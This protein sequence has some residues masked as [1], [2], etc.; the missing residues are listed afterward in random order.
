[1]DREKAAAAHELAALIGERARVNHIVDNTFPTRAKSLIDD[2]VRVVS[3]GGSMPR[4]MKRS[5]G[6]WMDAHG[7]NS[8]AGRDF[9]V[10]AV[11]VGAVVCFASAAAFA[12]IGWWALLPAIPIG[13]TV[14]F[15]GKLLSNKWT[16][17]TVLGVLKDNNVDLPRDATLQD[18]RLAEYMLVT[19]V[20]E[21]Q[22]LLGK[23]TG[24]RYFADLNATD[25]ANA[26]KEAAL[27][28]FTT[29]ESLDVGRTITGR[30]TTRAG[31]RGS[32]SNTQ[33]SLKVAILIRRNVLMIAFL[34]SYLSK[35]RLEIDKEVNTYLVAIDDKISKAVNEA[36]KV[37][38]H[39]IRCPQHCCYGPSDD[40]LTLTRLSSR[41]PTAGGGTR[42]MNNRELNDRARIHLRTARAAVTAVDIHGANTAHAAVASNSGGDESARQLIDR[43]RAID[44]GATAGAEDLI[45]EHQSEGQEARQAFGDFDE[46]GGVDVIQGTIFNASTEAMES[47]LSEAVQ[48]S[49]GGM[50]ADLAMGPVGWVAGIVVGEVIQSVMVNRPTESAVAHIR[51]ATCV[52]DTKLK[53]DL[54]E[55]LGKTSVDFLEKALQRAHT[56]YLARVKTRVTKLHNDPIVRR[57]R[58]RRRRPMIT[59]PEAVRLT[60]YV[61]KCWRYAIKAE[62]NI[63]YVYQAVVNLENHMKQAF[64]T[65]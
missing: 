34:K 52:S 49:V 15:T 16:K 41:V 40:D 7:T 32:E 20:K 57:L 23:K 17:R 19:L 42:R 5:T 22:R 62:T 9:Y 10:F 37:G 21:Y 61:Y 53:E 44:V 11:G 33:A 54:V 1:M 13:F 39:H 65:S 51:N 18:G 26:W 4:R 56:H 6:A 43:L 2:T 8:R 31:L 14:F 45:G 36:V 35:L 60:R 46:Y 27:K 38:S 59:C 25:R 55:E 63:T 29:T 3:T 28:G 12:A 50:G 64:P 58:S 30:F 24:G 48:E 47:T